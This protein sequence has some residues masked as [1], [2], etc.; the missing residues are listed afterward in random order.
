[1]STS[2]T[3]FAS[4]TT[5]RPVGRPRTSKWITADLSRRIKERLYQLRKSQIDLAS[6]AEMPV[7]SLRGWLNGNQGISVERLDKVLDFV[8][9]CE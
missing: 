4:P 2:T 1:M 5:T 8:G 6:A 7:D 3:S 9:I